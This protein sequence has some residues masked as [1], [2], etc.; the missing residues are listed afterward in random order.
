MQEL[1][2][3]DMQKIEIKLPQIEGAEL[4][5]VTTNIENGYIVAEYGEKV[6][7]PKFKKGDI[8]Y[9]PHNKKWNSDYFAI[10]DNHSKDE[11]LCY[12]V[13][14]SENGG[15]VYNSCCDADGFRLATPEEQQILFDA[16]V[17]EGKYWDAEA[18]E[19]K[20]IPKEKRIKNIF[21]EL[22]GHNISVNEAYRQINNIT[23]IN[24]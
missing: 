9:A 20:D 3:E 5:N 22:R 1:N 15:F 4:K 2:K 18:L 24:G 21:R 11:S 14:F 16:L 12:D 17:K 23:P 6:Q 19:V 13:M 7:E 10:Y 8:L